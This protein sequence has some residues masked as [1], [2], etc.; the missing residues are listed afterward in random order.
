VC[1]RVACRI[2]A[3]P[4][5][6]LTQMPCATAWLRQSQA[7]TAAGPALAAWAR[8]VGQ[9]WQLGPG[10]W[11]SIGR[12]GQVRGPALAGRARWVAGGSCIRCVQHPRPAGHMH[13]YEPVF[14]IRQSACVRMCSKHDVFLLLAQLPPPPGATAVVGECSPRNS[15]GCPSLELSAYL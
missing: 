8:W 12:S 11:A 2:W 9:H 4:Q 7:S 15:C 1:V 5:R 13:P 10:G 14:C 3:S 6:M